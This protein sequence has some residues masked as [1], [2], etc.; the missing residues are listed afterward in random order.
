MSSTKT[1]LSGVAA[2]L[3]GV[4][5]IIG[6]FASGDIGTIEWSVTIGSIVTGIGL[7]FGRDNDTTDKG[8]K[9]TK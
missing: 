8:A 3:V 5:T 1:T 9:A 4:G 7:I 6:A 2:I